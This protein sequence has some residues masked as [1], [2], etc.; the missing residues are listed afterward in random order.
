MKMND[1]SKS[2]RELWEIKDE[3]YKEVSG[4]PIKD[5]LRKRLKDSMDTLKRLGFKSTSLSQKSFKSS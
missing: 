3:C 4:L 5:A 2:L 1:I